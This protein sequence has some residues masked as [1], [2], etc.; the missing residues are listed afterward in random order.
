MA[1]VIAAGDVRLASV[2][3]VGHA[4]KTAHRTCLDI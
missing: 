3:A 1:S 4:T 2:I